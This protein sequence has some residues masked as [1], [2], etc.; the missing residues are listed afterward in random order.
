MTLFI[1]FWI[2]KEAQV[3]PIDGSPNTPSKHNKEIKAPKIGMK[4]DCYDNAY[5]F[6]KQYAHKMDFNVRKHY[7]RKCWT[8]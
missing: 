5:E 4:F 8:C 1:G 7:I 3:E 6:Y 2:Q